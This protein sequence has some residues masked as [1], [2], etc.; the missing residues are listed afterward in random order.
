MPAAELHSASYAVHRS[1]SE[2]AIDIF[3]DISDAYLLF[4]LIGTRSNFVREKKIMFFVH[5]TACNTLANTL[6]NSRKT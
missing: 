5:L 2:S 4:C 3:V 6:A 1:D